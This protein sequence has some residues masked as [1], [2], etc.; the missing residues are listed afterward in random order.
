LPWS[1]DHQGFITN[2][3]AILDSKPGSPSRFLLICAAREEDC[4]GVDVL[5]QQAGVK[6]AFYLKGGLA[7][8]EAYLQQISL[9]AQPEKRTQQGG[10]KCF[11]CP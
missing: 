3:K 8:Y 6:N 2:L 7:G 1:R 10:L 9:L 4:A 11:K 5:L